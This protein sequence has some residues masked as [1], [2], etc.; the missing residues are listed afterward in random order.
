MACV[1]GGLCLPVADGVGRDEFEYGNWLRD[2]IDKCLGCG[3]GLDL[4]YVEEAA[5]GC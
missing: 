3:L 4:A 1:G 2:G 5:V